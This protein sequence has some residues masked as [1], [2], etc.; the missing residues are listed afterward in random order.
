[1]DDSPK[2]IADEAAAVYRAGRIKL[3]DAVDLV[4]ARH[5]ALNSAFL[6]REQ[7]RSKV[8][9]ILG[10]RG[11]L[12]KKRRSRFRDNFLADVEGSGRAEIERPPSHLLFAATP[13]AP[14]ECGT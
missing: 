6:W 3:K 14:A 8:F 7:V 13:S 4:I 10:K 1:M 11:A 2:T 5:D 12:T 9:S